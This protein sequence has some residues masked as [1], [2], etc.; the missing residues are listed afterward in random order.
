MLW[1]ALRGTDQAGPW[2]GT[3]PV[4]KPEAA[5]CAQFTRGFNR[6]VLAKWRLFSEEGALA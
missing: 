2:I 4:Y 3:S 6:M 5:A 1:H